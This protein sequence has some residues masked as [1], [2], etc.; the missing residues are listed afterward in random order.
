[1][2]TVGHQLPSP[3]GKGLQVGKGDFCSE[4]EGTGPGETTCVQVPA[5]LL[6]V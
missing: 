6:T 1:M 2:F 3:E 4:M 5:P